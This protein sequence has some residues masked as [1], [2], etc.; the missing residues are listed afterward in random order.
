[1]ENNK[2]P[3]LEHSWTHIWIAWINS[4]IDKTDVNFH[5]WLQKNYNLPN[6]K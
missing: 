5:L 2:L 1:M 6:S 4:D 3:E